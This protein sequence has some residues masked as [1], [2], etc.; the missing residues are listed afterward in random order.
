MRECGSAEKFGEISN[1]RMKFNKFIQKK[2]Q[3]VNLAFFCLKYLKLNFMINAFF[4]QI[5]YVCI[6][7]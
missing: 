7:F 3:D 6:V 4:K 5:L 1:G 2:K